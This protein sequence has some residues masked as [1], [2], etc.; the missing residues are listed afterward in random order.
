MREGSFTNKATQ[1]CLK[2]LLYFLNGQ[3]KYQ[4]FF[5]L[6]LTYKYII[7]PYL[8]PEDHTTYNIKVISVLSQYLNLKGKLLYKQVFL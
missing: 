8:F 7:K 2:K 4:A 1:S 3:Y 5:V 6:Y